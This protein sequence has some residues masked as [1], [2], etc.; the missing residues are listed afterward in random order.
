M[1]SPPIG[2]LAD[3]TLRALHLL[4]LVDAVACETPPHPSLLQAY[5]SDGHCW[6][7]TS[8]TRPKRRSVIER[9]QRGERVVY[10]SDAGTPGISDPGAR[11]A[12]RSRPPD[13]ARSR[14]QAPAA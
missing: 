3:I 12:Q 14:C 10:V 1:W 8:T 2:N 6:R 7:C 9:L 13:C 4:G 5:G 11:L